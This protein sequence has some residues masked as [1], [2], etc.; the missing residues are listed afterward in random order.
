MQTI[1][2]VTRNVLGFMASGPAPL[3]RTLEFSARDDQMVAKFTEHIR[4]ASSSDPVFNLLNQKLSGWDY[5]GGAAWAGGTRSN[6]E[7]RRT[8]IYELLE[9]D[10]D[11]V[12]L[13]DEKFPPNLNHDAPIVIAR[14]H[15]PW[16]DD[17]RQARQAF[18]RNAYANYLRTKKHWT[19]DQIKGLEESTRLV[20]E[21]LSDPERPKI[22]PVRG[23]VVGYV[24]SGKTAN[25]TGV[26]ARAADAGYRLIVVLAGTLNILRAQTQRRIDR[27]LIGRPFITAE[28]DSEYASE[29]DSFIDHGSLPSDRGAFD[30]NRLT[31]SREDFQRLVHGIESLRFRQKDRKKPFNHPDNLHVESARLLVV[32]KN[33]AVLKKFAEDLARVQKNQPLADIP[34]LII[35]DESDQA[36]VN[37][38]K[39]TAKEVQKRTATNSAIVSLLKQLP[40]AQYVGYTATPFANVFVDPNNEEDLFPKDFIISLPRPVNYMGVADF[41]D[42]DRPDKE[43]PGPNEK[44]YVRDVTGDDSDPANLPQAIDSYLL[45]GALKL[46][47]AEKMPGLEKV[48][49]HHTMLVHISHLKDSHH[50]TA[51]L[52]S[53]LLATGGYMGSSAWPR[54]KKLWNEDFAPVCQ[55]R[56]DGYPVPASFEELK[57][58]F[59]KCFARL[60]ATLKP[61]LTIN[62]DSEDN[63]DFESSSVWNIVVGGA[64]LSRGY[65]IEGLTV[66]YYRRRAGTA[67]SLMQMGRWFG[68]RDGYR[69]MVRLYIG[70]SEPAGRGVATDGGKAGNRRKGGAEAEEKT[71]DLFRAFEAA[72]LDEME[73]RAELKRYADPVDGKRILPRQ[74]PP[75]VPS[76]LLRPTSLNKMYNAT[77]EFKNFA[78]AWKEH[79]VAPAGEKDIL[80]NQNLL[81]S[82]LEG[83]IETGVLSVTNQDGT[84]ERDARWKTITAEAMLTFL[85]AYRWAGGDE[86]VLRRE[87]EFLQSKNNGISEW[88]FLYF[89]GPERSKPCTIGGS[90]FKVYNRSRTDDGRFGVYSE[91]V[92]RPIVKYLCGVEDAEPNNDVTRDLMCANR[93]VFVF[94]PTAELK[95]KGEISS[96]LITPGFALQFPDN[97]NP[98]QIS[99]GVKVKSREDEPIADAAPEAVQ[100]KTKRKVPGTRNT[101][102]KSAAGKK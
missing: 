42:L 43:E 47:R 53:S 10:G 71:I 63:P 15:T 94:Y 60:H 30:W 27:E 66:S 26:V 6:S 35:D 52:V 72:C 78:K 64:K 13:F 9:I 19:E 28:E 55:S 54:L 84:F 31:G 83:G 38:N 74:V 14:E 86:N 99:F 11:L 97:D 91:S 24:Q 96:S 82:L 51:D 25:F 16:Y 59:G 8:K 61:V 3:A 90:A 102:K 48:F 80:H 34:T 89:E 49:R 7:E 68:F 92:H 18:Y 75:L 44:A 58:F 57:P 65:T 98:N 37:T 93:A 45:A 85:K 50:D 23:L 21:R 12:K 46:Y 67:D 70:R 77:I 88:L 81:A 29:L 39:P 76:H 41:H 40:R 56:S 20:M 1:F 32:K 87:I 69:D 33:P 95:R 100:E 101:A 4:A 5:D 22:Y 73:F 36:S 79:T 2:D 17:A 62:G